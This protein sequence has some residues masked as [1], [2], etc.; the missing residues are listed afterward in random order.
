MKIIQVSDTHI[1]PPGRG[2]W[3]F[4]PRANLEA[5]VDDINARHGDA[6][7][8]IV[9]GDLTDRGEPEAYAELREI[10]A[11]LRVPWRLTATRGA[12]RA[13]VTGR[14]DN[15]AAPRLPAWARSFSPTT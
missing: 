6:D 4:N 12:R 9:T 10:L 3:G 15:T 8:C 11:P 13:G 5:C 1:V 2:L 7:L 14:N